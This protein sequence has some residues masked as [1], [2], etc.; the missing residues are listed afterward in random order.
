MVSVM[1][2]ISIVRYLHPHLKGE[3]MSA[4][5]IH[6]DLL[7]TLGNEAVAYSRVTKYLRTAQFGPT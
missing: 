4:Q 1:D 5:T 2:Q 6:N 3:E 7:A